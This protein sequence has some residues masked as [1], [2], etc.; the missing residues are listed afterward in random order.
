[1]EINGDLNVN[2]V[3][4]CQCFPDEADRTVMNGI[5]GMLLVPFRDE[6]LASG[7]PGLHAAALPH[8]NRA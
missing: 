5:M 4:T 7:Q 3:A 1:L 2:K 6:A 8:Q